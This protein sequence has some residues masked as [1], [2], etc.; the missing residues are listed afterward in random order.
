MIGLDQSWPGSDRAGKIVHVPAFDETF[1][2]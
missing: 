2:Q 1:E